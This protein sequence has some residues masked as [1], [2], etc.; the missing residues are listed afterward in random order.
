MYQASYSPRHHPSPTRLE[1]IIEEQAFCAACTALGATHLV[2]GNAAGAATSHKT[3]TESTRRVR[4]EPVD[5]RD[6]R[7]PAVPV[8]MNDDHERYVL[9][10]L[11]ARA[12]EIPASDSQGLYK[13]AKSRVK[14]LTCLLIVR[15]T[16][17][18]GRATMLQKPPQ[19]PTFC[20]QRPT[21]CCRKRLR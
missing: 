1:P 16:A 17:L 15:D 13:Q 11:L 14:S 18:T 6:V 12:S 5:Q 20:T 4:R 8:A 3:R 9:H 21:S 19:D 7:I 10:A 2:L